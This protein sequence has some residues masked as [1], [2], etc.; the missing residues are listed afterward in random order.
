MTGYTATYQLPYLLGTDPLH[1]IDDVTLA[2]ANRLEALIN[3][4]TIAVPG[5]VSKSGDTMTGTLQLF[6]GSNF[7]AWLKQ[8]TSAVASLLVSVGAET[9]FRFI[10]GADGKMLW[11]N[12]AASTDTTLE[13]AAAGVLKA[14]GN[15]IRAGANVVSADTTITADDYLNVL[16]GT[17]A[18]AFTLPA[19]SGNTGVELVF[20]NRCTA[21]VNLTI[22]RAGINQI[23]SDGTYATAGAVTSLALPQHKQVRVINDGT[24]WL[25]V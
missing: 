9:D 1:T 4:G 17:T 23:W 6:T 12:G 2:L 21:A 11:G 18:R 5:K 15:I 7:G 16:T 13:R 14:N 24:Y 25:Q 3:A 20:K 22:Q 8:A 10:L 19:I